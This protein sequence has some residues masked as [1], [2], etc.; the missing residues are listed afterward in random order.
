MSVIANMKAKTSR[1]SV[2][3]SIS[4]TGKGTSASWITWPTFLLGVLGLLA[5]LYCFYRAQQHNAQILVE[6]QTLL[7]QHRLSDDI[8]RGWSQGQGV[9]ELGKALDLFAERHQLFTDEG[10]GDRI[11]DVAD[12][13]SGALTDLRTELSLAT[14]Q[15][16]LGEGLSNVDSS[17]GDL[18]DTQDTDSSGNGSALSIDV[19]A[20]NLI[21]TTSTLRAMLAR[22]E[23]RT[24]QV[25]SAG[26]LYQLSVSV[27][28]R[29]GINS[30]SSN[31]PDIAAAQ[32]P[33]LVF[34]QILQRMEA[35]IGSSEITDE[36]H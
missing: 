20:A 18:S 9:Q 13:V 14:E 15:G 5:S 29:L 28:D 26:H 3:S 24:I 1:S 31:N 32:G 36:R 17:A 19:A 4:G 34:D 6:Q 11:T 10:R 8:R 16:G 12:R 2:A 7:N 21:E 22:D 25:E 30:G 27:G 23:A 35:M 33:W